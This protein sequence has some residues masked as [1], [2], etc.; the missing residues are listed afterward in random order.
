MRYL[1]LASRPGENSL[2]EETQV[3][4]ALVPVIKVLARSIAEEFL[5]LREQALQEMD[6][7]P[8]EES[9]PQEPRKPGRRKASRGKPKPTA[10]GSRE[11]GSVVKGEG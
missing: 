5:A 1:S 7:L 11:K 4:E 2:A 3:T 10:E 9:P 6:Q 8:P